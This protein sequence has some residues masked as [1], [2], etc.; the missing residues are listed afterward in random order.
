MA[1]VPKVLHAFYLNFARRYH[2]GFSLST[3][4]LPGVVAGGELNA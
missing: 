2:P 1:N 4:P 3:Q